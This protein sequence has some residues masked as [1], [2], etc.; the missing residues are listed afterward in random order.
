MKSILSRL[1]NTQRELHESK[2]ILS[3][4]VELCSEKGSALLGFRLLQRPSVYIVVCYYIRHFALQTH[5]RLNF[6]DVE[7]DKF[8]IEKSNIVVFAFLSS[9]SRSI[10]AVAVTAAAKGFRNLSFCCV[11]VICFSTTVQ[12]KYMCNHLPVS[13]FEHSKT[14][15]HTHAHS[16]T[17]LL[18]FRKPIWLLV[19]ISLFVYNS[20]R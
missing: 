8:S 16:H 17:Q 19:S 3:I 5:F 9:R 10:K 12:V 15:V 1:A 11:A 13:Y 18:A 7:Y 20:Q 6:S 4:E 14:Y 2:V